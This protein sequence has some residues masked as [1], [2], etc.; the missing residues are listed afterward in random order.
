MPTP[1]PTD[2]N[3]RTVDYD[4]CDGLENIPTLEAEKG[5]WTLNATYSPDWT[6]LAQ[7]TDGYTSTSILKS[8]YD[9]TNMTVN[10]TYLKKDTDYGQIMAVALRSHAVSTASDAAWCEGHAKY[11]CEVE[12][13]DVTKV[14]L[15]LKVCTNDG[16][17]AMIAS[18]EYKPFSTE[19]W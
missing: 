5:S 17:Y 7:N 19:N 2:D 14:A 11:V 1:A 6:C 12:A 4:F 15:H 3:V 16:D 18:S 9:M 10:V 8:L 13:E